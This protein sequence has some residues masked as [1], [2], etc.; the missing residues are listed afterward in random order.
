MPGIRRIR[1]GPSFI[2]RWPNGRRVTGR[3]ALQRIAAL[4]IPP[5]YEEVWVCT[6]PR[7]HL[8][9][10]GHDARQRK[11]YR[12]HPKWRMTRDTEKFERIASFGEALPRLRRRLR[13]D[14][15]LHGLPRQKVLALVV[16]LLDATRLRIGSA[17][18]AR[19]NDSYGL[20]TL[21]NRHAQFICDDKLILRFRGKGGA[22]HEIEVDDE[23]LIRL[24]RWCHQLPGQQLFQC[25]DDCGEAAPI[26]SDDVNRY[27]KEAMGKDFT[28]KDFRTWGATLHATMIMHA[29]P[30][31][32]RRRQAALRRCI[33]EATKKV[34][35]SL[36]NTPAVCRKSYINPL[37]FKA[38]RTGELHKSIGERMSRAPRR[39]ERFIP[40]LLR[41]Q[42]L[43]AG[44]G[45]AYP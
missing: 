11:Q 18:Y 45:H 2:Y 34:A 21:R 35:G 1:A 26:S 12:Y 15:A 25:V 22:K 32:P 44:R 6:D 19:D 3:A 5:A 16:S 40:A 9:A 20:T 38:W 10:T 41:R 14:L 13:R 37:V 43:A 27:L 17:A 8:Q 4:A 42:A 36:G 7:G 29:T 28:A 24:V 39:T 31:P 30:L 33:V 23:K